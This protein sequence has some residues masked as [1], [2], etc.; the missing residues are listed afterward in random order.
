MKQ[1]LSQLHRESGFVILFS[2]LISTIILIMSAGIFRVAQKETILSSYSRESQ[3]AFYAADGGV[4][5]AIFWDISNF[6]T[7]TRFSRSQPSD[8]NTPSFECGTDGDGDPRSIQAYKYDT[9]GVYDHVFGFRYTNEGDDFGCSFVFVEKNDPA[10]PAAPEDPPNPTET[11]IT[12][13]GYNVCEE[14]IPDLDD[15]T[16]LERR[17]SVRY[18]AQ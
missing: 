3:K 15:P 5:C 4:E 17:L 8:S 9:S 13:V 12:A 16:L 11:R 14:D 7:Q 18:L 1:R 10:P 2:I 6:V